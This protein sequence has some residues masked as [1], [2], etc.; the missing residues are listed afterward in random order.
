MLL[1]FKLGIAAA[2]SLPAEVIAAA[3]ARGRGR[4]LHATVE[5]LLQVLRV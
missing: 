5:E 1:T 4:D 2:A 3:Q